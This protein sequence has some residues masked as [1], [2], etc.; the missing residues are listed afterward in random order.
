MLS[1]RQWIWCVF[2]PLLTTVGIDQYTKHWARS[3]GQPFSVGPVTFILHNN[4]GFMLGGLSE[5]TKLYTV[6][7]PATLGAFI[8]FVF[9]VV[10]YFLPI[11]S[12]VMRSGLSLLL[13]GFVGNIVDRILTGYV[14]D[15]LFMKTAMVSTGVFNVADAM[16]WLGVTIFLGSFIANGKLLYPADQRRNRKW[17]DPK[18]QIRYCST[19]V[20]AGLG[21]SIVGGVLS[22]TFLSVSV[23]KISSISIVAARD[24]ISGFIIVYSITAF[25]FF[26]ALF[27]LGVF[28]S[29]RIAGPI[30]GFENFIEDLLSGK[31]REFKLRQND[32]FDQLEALATRFHTFF[33]EKLGIDPPGLAPGMRAPTFEAK[34]YD[35]NSVNI[36]T[37]IGSKVWI[38]FYRYATCPLCA[39]HLSEV[40]NLLPELKANNTKVIAVYES[41]PDQFLKADTGGTAELLQSLD[42]PLI[43]DPQRKLYR[44]Y[45]SRTNKLMLLHPSTFKTFFNAKKQNY[46]QGSIDGDIGQLPAHFLIDEQGKVVEAFYGR[47]LTDHISVDRLRTFVNPTHAT[48]SAI[49]L[50]AAK[51]LAQ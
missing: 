27:I 49:A 24:Y 28:M 35:G 18:F 45:R 20:L 25:T 14:T 23:A 40:R 22:Y 31:S 32:E 46:R 17:I 34:S 8:L 3:L 9:F 7:V 1:W 47:N 29:H 10:Q 38:I 6:V 4:P 19:L 39:L 42:I 37:Y 11:R 5:L 2:I 12:L 33:H 13:G 41:T 43:A 26:I 16:Q 44:A 50:S 30:R 48:P 15:F 36:N 51:N 21:F